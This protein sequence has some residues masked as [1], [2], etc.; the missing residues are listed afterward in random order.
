MSLRM[1][2]DDGSGLAGSKTECETAAHEA[3]GARQQRNLVMVVWEGAIPATVVDSEAL[4]GQ[5]SQFWP[6]FNAS[7][8]MVWDQNRLSM[9][10]ASFA[11]RHAGLHM[12]RLRTSRECCWW[13]QRM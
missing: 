3:A 13:R 1:C 11:A 10:L 7:C 4:V 6:P 2:C 9:L 12:E 8:L 5:Q